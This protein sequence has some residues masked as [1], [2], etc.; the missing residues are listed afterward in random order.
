MKR[1]RVV[2][3][4]GTRPEIIRLSRILVRLDE[5]FEHVI[6]HTGQNYDPELNKIFFEDLNLR[7]PDYYLNSAEQSQSPSNTIGNIISSVDTLLEDLKPDAL[8]VLGDTNSCLSVIPAKRRK[9]PIFHFEAG[10]RCFDERVPEEINRKIVDHV[11]DVNLTYSSIAR[12]Y[13]IKE[14]IPQDR[15][16]KLGSPMAEVLGYYS[17]KINS[18]LILEELNLER[19]NFFVISLHR[20]KY[21]KPK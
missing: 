13:L 14:G 3:V 16:I 8:L 4:M 1:L 18:S 11:A 15:V 5:T 2:T 17:K 12:E 6:V 19:Q 9:I 20:R 10:N 21:R 7:E